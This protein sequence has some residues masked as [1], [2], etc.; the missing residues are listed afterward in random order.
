MID[1][2]S[3]VAA[4]KRYLKQR[5]KY[6]ISFK[7]T[8]NGPFTTDRKTISK[9]VLPGIDE[10]VLQTI[11]ERMYESGYIIKDDGITLSFSV[12]FVFK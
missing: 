2:M 1:D 10:E 3:M 9:D 6:Q 8:K 12:D 7:L 4:I 5:Y 11:L